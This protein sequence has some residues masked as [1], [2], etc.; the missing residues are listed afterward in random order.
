MIR[1]Y[2]KYIY[3]DP[4]A[5]AFMQLT[6]RANEECYVDGIEMRRLFGDAVVSIHSKSGWIVDVSSLRSIDAG[7]GAA[8][9]P[10]S[11]ASVNAGS[12]ADQEPGDDDGDMPNPMEP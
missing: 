10:D 3:V 11:D 8:S 6:V 4:Y 5:N 1:Y 9:S 2:K 12:G 7:S